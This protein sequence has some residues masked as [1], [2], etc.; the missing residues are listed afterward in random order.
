MTRSRSTRGPLLWSPSTAIAAT[1]TPPWPPCRW[2]RSTPAVTDSVASLVEFAR[3]HSIRVIHVILNNRVLPDG[4][5]ELRHN[6]FWQTVES[7]NQRLTP[8]L[9]STISGHNLVGSPQAELMPELGPDPTDLVLRTKRR[10]SIFRGTDLDLT[11]QQL[12]IDT[13]V[14]M[15]INTNTCVQCAAFESLNRN[16]ED[17]R[18][19]RGRALNVRGRPPCLRTAEHRAVP[20]MGA[21]PRSIHHQGRESPGRTAGAA[22][23]APAVTTRDR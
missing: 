16:P 3:R 15:G 13:V 1:S 14:L 4:V 18:H 10:L 7:I 17:D 6:R 19:R 22:R 2:P 12:R 20:R 11:L 23:E 9:T 8:T 5:V 21:F